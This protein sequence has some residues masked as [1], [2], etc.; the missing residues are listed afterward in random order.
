MLFICTFSLGLHA[1][2]LVVPFEQS[3]Q[4][5]R[6]QLHIL[7]KMNVNEKM[8][9]HPM[10]EA[11]QCTHTLIRNETSLVYLHDIDVL[12]IEEIGLLN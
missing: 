6:T 11:N 9:C 3:N 1:A 8:T 4:S 7:L 5:G 2:I 10:L 12:I